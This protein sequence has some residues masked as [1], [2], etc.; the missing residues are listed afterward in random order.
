[1]IV[2]TVHMLLCKN[3]PVRQ[4]W[5]GAEILFGCAVP[6]SYR[7]LGRAVQDQSGKKTTE[8]NLTEQVYLK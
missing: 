3:I 6:E 7:S 2:T 8:Q 5:M 4:Q 1:M